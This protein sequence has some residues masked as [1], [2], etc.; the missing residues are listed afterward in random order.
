[1]VCCFV[2]VPKPCWK[3]LVIPDTSAPRSAFSACSIPGTRNLSFIPM[4]TAWFQPADSRSITRAGFGPGLASFSPSTCCGVF[5]AASS[6]LLSSQAFQRGPTHLLRGSGS[7]GAT[8][9]LRFLAPA[10]VPKGLGGLLQTT[11]RRPRVCAPISRPL[12]PP[13]GHLQPS[14][15]RLRHGQVTFRWRDSAH[16]NEQKL[17]TLSVDEFLRR[18]LL[19]LLPK[20]FVRI[21]HFGFLAHRRRATLCPFASLHSA[22]SP[23]Q[24]HPLSANEPSR[25]LRLCPY[26]GAPMV[27]VERLTAAQIQLR[28]PPILAKV[29][30]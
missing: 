3:W 25:D 9:G 7:S 4:S 16:G 5:F 14:P 18:F 21:R 27:I 10:T 15:G 26:C 17:M 19:H 29:A 8:E 20:G 2:P 30:A 13:R 23:H 12:H 24:I 22:P 6:S 11:L 1:M 28:S